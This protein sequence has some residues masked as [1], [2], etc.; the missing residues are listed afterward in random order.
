M[1][2]LAAVQNR[3]G[4]DACLMGKLLPNAAAMR[5]L[6]LGFLLF[7]ALGPLPGRAVR[8]AVQR[9]D[10]VARAIPVH[11]SGRPSGALRFVQGWQLVSPNSRFGGFSA[12][13]RIAPG[14][15]LLVGDNGVWTRMTLG[16]D[17]VVSELAIHNLP[18]PFHYPTGKLYRDSESLVFDPEN[19]KSW[20]GLEHI[21]QIWRLSPDM[22]RVESRSRPKAMAR[23]PLNSGPEAMVRLADGRTIIFSEKADADPRGT[24]ALIY[25]GDPAVPG[26][27]PLR[28]FY[29]AQGK[30]LI[31][32]AAPLPDG[33]ILIVHR[34]LGFNPVFTT[35]IAIADPADIES[36]GVLRSRPIGRV[37]LA[38]AD[39]FEGAVV[40]VMGGRPYL[41]LVS[42]N[43]FNVWQR[44]LLLQ[45]ALVNLPPRKIADSKKV[46]PLPGRP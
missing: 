25:H 36:D 12:L 42:D 5:R 45:F 31:S 3:G 32:D 16:D 19:G 13:A 43:N 28:F 18:R 40:A 1:G 26:E 35:I 11:F 21:N 22:T 9:D 23:W 33:R 14:Q 46:A 6:F 39:N 17:G 27:A 44:S 24:E 15:F 38:L 7:V 29:D 20:I 10:Q 34:R 41:W 2:L 30:G 4:V 37:P 8:Y